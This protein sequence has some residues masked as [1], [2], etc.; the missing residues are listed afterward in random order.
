MAGFAGGL[1]PAVHRAV[2]L[3]SL[4][5]VGQLVSLLPWSLL[6]A[7]PCVHSP[8]G[9]QEEAAQAGP[10]SILRGD[11]SPKVREHPGWV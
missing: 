4:A 2:L 7:Q 10:G 1:P 9:G 5:P 6:W 8:R 11:D 3:S